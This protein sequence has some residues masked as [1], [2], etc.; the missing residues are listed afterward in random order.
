M[1]CVTNE[2]DVVVDGT[3]GALDYILA[4]SLDVASVFIPWDDSE[5]GLVSLPGLKQ[6]VR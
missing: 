2:R 5:H 3:D 1:G 6:V 4:C